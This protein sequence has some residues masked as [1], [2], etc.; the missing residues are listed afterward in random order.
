MRPITW[1]AKL[2]KESVEQFHRFL[3]PLIVGLGRSERRV[4]AARY[5]E[6]LLMPGHRKS[7]GPMAERLG[8]DSQSLQQF[9]T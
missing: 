4:A 1:N 9:V 8:V 7:I 5:V 3:Q 6:G 2:W